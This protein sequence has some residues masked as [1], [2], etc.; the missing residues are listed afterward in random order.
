MIVVVA[1]SKGGVGKPTV[2]AHLAAWLAARGARVVLADCDAQASS[3]EWLAE[4]APPGGTR[5]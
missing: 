4:A 3:S 1:N 5:P 2:A